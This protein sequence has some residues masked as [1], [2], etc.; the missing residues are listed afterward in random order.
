MSGVITIG[1]WRQ[2]FERALDN[3]PA[4]QGVRRDLADHCDEWGDPDGGPLRWLADHGKFPSPP[5]TDHPTRWEWFPM[6][7]RMSGEEMGYPHESDMPLELWRHLK[8]HEDGRYFTR[9]GAEADFCIAYRIAIRRGW[10]P[11]E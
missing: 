8:K 11:Y 6:F 9:F 4:D 1:H 7:S 10:K 5:G 3:D 2:P